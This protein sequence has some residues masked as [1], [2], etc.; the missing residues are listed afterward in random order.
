MCQVEAENSVVKAHDKLKSCEHPSFLKIPVNERI[1]QMTEF[2][3]KIKEIFNKA[4]FQPLMIEDIYNANDLVKKSY[5]VL[6][7]ITNDMGKSHLINFLKTYMKNIA[8][9]SFQSYLL[10]QKVLLIQYE[11]KF[12]VSIIMSHYFYFLFL[13]VLILETFEILDALL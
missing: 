2:V 4:E 7:D 1:N 3:Q 5:E 8:C 6:Q 10:L 12:C 11:I 13:T 9:I